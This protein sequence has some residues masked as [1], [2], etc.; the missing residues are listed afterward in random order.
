MKATRLLQLYQEGRRDFSSENLRGQNFNGA[1]LSGAD[2]TDADIRSANFINANLT[3]ANFSQ[4]K[5]GFQR[6]WAT[7]LFV[8]SFLLSGIGGCFSGFAFSMIELIY[9]SSFEKL[10]FGS[11]FANQFASWAAFAILILVLLLVYR[12]GIGSGAILNGST[13][14][15]SVAVA[16]AV[17]LTVALIGFATGGVSSI[18]DF[19]DAV[20][21]ILAITVS[22]AVDTAVIYTGGLAG[23]LAIEVA[24][25]ILFLVTDAYRIT[26]A[27]T[28]A[29]GCV[30]VILGL[31]ASDYAVSGAIAIATAIAGLIAG[32]VVAGLWGVY[33]GWRELHGDDRN[34]W[35][36][37]AATTFALIGGTRFRGANL[38]DANLTQAQIDQTDL[39]GAVVIETDMEG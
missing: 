39:T 19:T 36:R 31:A 16:L 30:G 24:S 37:S 34:V 32:I 7:G 29:I 6:R 4:A 22:S 5:V 9:N 11:S 12:R 21:G 33:I 13:L 28:V 15:F 38:T 20:A 23:V 1:D 26:F 3:G 27:V 17:T 2:F 14:I 8:F 35:V 25:D 10:T 18:G